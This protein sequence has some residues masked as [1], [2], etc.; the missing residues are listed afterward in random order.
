MINCIFV[1]NFSFKSFPSGE[2]SGVLDLTAHH[3][4]PKSAIAIAEALR[5]DASFT[6]VALRDCM[7]GDEGCCVVVEALKSNRYVTH[8]DL[9]YVAI[10]FADC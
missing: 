9:K 10:F 8:L 6:R 7:L 4:N 1:N 5:T 3:V 2:Q